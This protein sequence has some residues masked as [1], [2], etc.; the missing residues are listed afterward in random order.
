MIDK[1]ACDIS[2][3]HKYKINHI[4]NDFMGLYDIH[5]FSL[6]LVDP[7]GNMIFFSKT[8][9][10]AYEICKRGYGDYDGIISPKYYTKNEFYW[11]EDAHHEKYSRKIQNI[12]EGIFKLKNGFMLVRNINGFYLLYSFATK[13]NSPKFKTNVVNNLNELY[14]IGDWA[15]SQLKDEYQLYVKHYIVPSIDKFN[16]FV[17]GKP[18]PTYTNSYKNSKLKSNVILLNDYI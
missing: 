12:R 9:S 11:W 4:F 16:P 6:D 5:H 13:S 1:L 8:P 15:Y 7:S 17:G 2:Y 14:K 3:I 18:K 10:H